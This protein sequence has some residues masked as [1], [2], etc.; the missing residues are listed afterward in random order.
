[1]EVPHDGRD[2]I[3]AQ[4]A[5]RLHAR[6]GLGTLQAGAAWPCTATT[7]GLVKTLIRD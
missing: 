3:S 7:G 4:E 2:G 5:A 1:M 6:P